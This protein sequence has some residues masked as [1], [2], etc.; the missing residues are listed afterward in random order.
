MEAGDRDQQDDEPIGIVISSGRASEPQPRVW[1]YVY[2]GAPA[3]VRAV[4]RAG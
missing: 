1:A 4:P 2:G 3:R